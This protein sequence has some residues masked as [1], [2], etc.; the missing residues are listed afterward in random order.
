ME[1]SEMELLF[2]SFLLLLTLFLSISL[3]L[4]SAQHPRRQRRRPEPMQKRKGSRKRTPQPTNSLVLNSVSVSNENASI[5][6]KLLGSSFQRL[7]QKLFPFYLQPWTRQEST[8]IGGLP[9]PW[10][11]KPQILRNLEASCD[12]REQVAVLADGD[13]RDDCPTVATDLSLYDRNYGNHSVEHSSTRSADPFQDLLS[14][15]SSM[16]MKLS[17]CSQDL[18]WHELTLGSKI[19]HSAGSPDLL[20]KFLREKVI[21]VTITKG[22]GNMLI[23]SEETLQMMSCWGNNILSEVSTVVPSSPKAMAIFIITREDRSS[24]PESQEISKY[25]SKTLLNVDSS[26]TNAV[27]SMKISVCRPTRNGLSKTDRLALPRPTADLLGR[28]TIRRD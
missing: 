14:G 26:D 17:V 10:F 23:R 6:S 27:V 4:M 18:S 7:I 21:E 24:N 3:R 22:R 5:I 2:L 16:E 20:R 9:L 1:N 28:R 13:E 12:L 19:H 15:F 11:I 8:H 25:A